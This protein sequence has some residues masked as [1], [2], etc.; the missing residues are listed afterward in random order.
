VVQDLEGEE[1]EVTIVF[2]AK[3]FKSISLKKLFD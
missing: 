3:R 1:L 2:F